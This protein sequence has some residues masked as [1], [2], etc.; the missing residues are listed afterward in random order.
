MIWGIIEERLAAGKSD[1]GGGVLARLLTRLGASALLRRPPAY[2]TAAFTGAYVALAAKMAAADGIAVRAEAVA[3]ESCLD[4]AE[5]DRGGL[6]R[7]YD[8]AKADTAGYEVYADRIAAMLQNEPEIKRNVFDCLMHVACSDGILHPAEDH[9]LHTVAAR[10]GYSDAEFHHIRSLFVHVADSP[11]AVLELTPGA[12]DA[13]IKSRYRKL[14]AEHHP[15]RLAAA[16][17]PPAVVR[18]ANAKLA[19]INAAY[20]EIMSERRAR[21]TP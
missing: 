18:S 5:A 7:L 10:F 14:A 20:Q 8:L 19:A 12:T 9:F 1:R 2:H 4:V 15:D 17:A 21:R 13:E 3:F 11:Y 6:R 16:G